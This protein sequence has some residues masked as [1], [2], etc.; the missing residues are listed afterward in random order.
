MRDRGLVIIQG[1]V[2]MMLISTY[3][4]SWNI[5]MPHIMRALG[6]D[7]AQIQLSYTL[8]VLFSTTSQ[9]LG[10]YLA[11]RHGPSLV[12]SI[13][14]L[15]AGIGMVSSAL[16]HDIY[17]FYA[18]WSI[19][20]LGVGLVY[21][22]AI[23]LGV[24]WFRGLRGLATGVINMGFGLGAAV[25][26][27]IFLAAMAHVNY[28]VVMEA[29]GVAMLLA[30]TPLMAT[31]RYPNIGGST[32][33]GVRIPPSFWVAFASFS[34]AGIPLQLYSSSVTVLGSGYEY[35]TIML[36]ASLL[37]LF[38]GIGRPVVGYVSDRIGRKITILS[39]SIILAAS[40]ALS[41][42]SPGTYLGS[43]IVVGLLGGSLITLYASL[44]GD[45]YGIRNST[46]LFGIMYNGKFVAAAL[47]SYTYAL[48]LKNMSVGSATLVE[49]ILTAVSIPI[50]A[51][52]MVMRSKGL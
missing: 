8:F 33:G 39:I 19:G 34:L 32:I 40:T 48:L 31:S 18:T 1:L 28:A 49:A 44:I 4:Y 3:Q 14:G 35:V 23:N 7:L 25:L 20:S 5:F 12:G 43:T 17:L 10:G 41:R 37:P 51:L 22:I 11:D 47:G 52:Y 15:L 30:I 21:G 9:V 16:V 42:I 29:V 36:A 27:P 2:P 45:E 50:L 46:L 38:S 6:V 24:K 26:N 13:G